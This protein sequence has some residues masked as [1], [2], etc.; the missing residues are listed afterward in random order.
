MTPPPE[1]D[2]ATQARLEA[3]CAAGWEFWET[4]DRT[5]RERG[6]HAFIPAEYEQ[7]CEALVAHFVPGRRFLEWGSGSGVI[8]ILA[9]II[10]YD[11]VGI[12]LDGAL[13]ETARGLARRFGSSARFVHGSFLPSGFRWHAAH[14][15]RNPE[16]TGDGRSGYIELGAALD[17][18]DVVYGYPWKGEEAMMRALM[19]EYGRRDAVLLL[20]DTIAGVRSFMDDRPVS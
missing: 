20:N 14:G 18:F 9:G 15:V 16:Q 7:V 11:A 12:E 10:G 6:F 3:V 4:F 2:A 17:D 5:V 19:R 13:V 8:T 1:I